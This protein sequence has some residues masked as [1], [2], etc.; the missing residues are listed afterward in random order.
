MFLGV[1]GKPEGRAL[2]CSQRQLAQGDAPPGAVTKQH[3][4]LHPVVRLQG[5]DPSLSGVAPSPLG[6]KSPMGS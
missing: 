4:L 6:Y 5:L 3:H 1:E 2:R